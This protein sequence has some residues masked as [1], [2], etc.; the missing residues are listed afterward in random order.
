ML[1][2]NKTKT[3]IFNY[4]DNH[5]F[6]TRLSVNGKNIQVVENT[7][8]LGTVISDDLKWDLNTDPLIKKANARMQLFH[9]MSNFGTPL[10][11][12]KDIYVL[13][14]RSSLEQSSSFWH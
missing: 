7:K 11:D 6:T 12:M 3:M 9:E 4:T 2:E 5:K 8:L 1:N 10:S 13:F 14:I